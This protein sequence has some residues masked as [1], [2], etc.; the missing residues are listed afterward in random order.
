MSADAK[1]AKHRFH[2]LD[3]LRGVAA[4]LIVFWH[5]PP[6]LNLRSGHATFLAVD[7]FFCLSGFVIAFSYGERLEYGLTALGFMRSRVVRLYP[8]YFAGLILGAA[9]FLAGHA[10][11]VTSWRHA[12]HILWLLLVEAVMLPNL[13]VWPSGLLFPINFPS[14]SIFFELMANAGF[15]VMAQG[16]RVGLTLLGALY[17]TFVTAFLVVAFTHQTLDF[18][19]SNE[20]WQICGGFA[21]VGLSFVAGIIILRIYRR[22]ST[23]WLATTIST[24]LSVA[25]AAALVLLLQTPFRAAS[26]A[27]NRINFCSAVVAFDCVFGSEVSRRRRSPKSVRLFRGNLLSSVP[28]ACASDLD[29]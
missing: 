2:F 29:S 24:P 16:R 22:L 18:G 28:A 9:P 27:P 8:V 21:R 3:A 11:P 1:F 13:A 26:F 15:A 20:A 12:S 6:Y 19:W 25:L 23:P 17:S 10:F 14:W 4:V 5:A 7:F